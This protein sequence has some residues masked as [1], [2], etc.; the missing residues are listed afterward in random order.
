MLLNILNGTF[1]IC[2]V[3]LLTL[4]SCSPYNSSFT[5]AHLQYLKAETK[6]V[7]K[8]AWGSY[9]TY[10]FPA[11][12]VR[13]LTC[14]P[15]GPD[16]NN[17]NDMIRNDAMGNISLTVLDNLDTLIIMEEWDELENMLEYLRNTPDIF[18]QDT[19]V[20]VFELSIRSLG[21]L[22]SA[23]LLLTDVT[24]SYV[25]AKFDKFKQVCDGYDGFL[26]DLAYDL[27]KRLIPTYKTSN[28]IPVPRVNL[29]KGVKDVPPK[30][31]RDACTAGAT[32]PVLEFTLL[33]RLTGDPQFEHYTQLTFWKFWSSKLVLNLLPMT[34]D[35]IAYKW[36]D[37]LTGIGAS[38][39]SFYEYSAKAAII[40][41]DKYMWSVFK[42]SYKALLTHL[43]I[44]GGAGDAT[45]IFTN[46]GVYDGVVTS[47]WIDLLG[48][49]WAGLQV[50]T[51]QVSDAIRT[52]LV[53]LKI[54]DTYDLIPER[55]IYSHFQKKKSY[56]VTDAI[57]LEWYPLRPEFIE[58]T[59]YLYRATKDPMYLKI[60]ER[61]LDLLNTRY[62]AKCG[63]SGVQDIR[64][65]K[66][67]NRMETFVL[68]ETLKYLYLLFDTQDES[69]LHSSLMN[70]KN[71]IFS[72]E[73]HP[74]WYHKKLKKER[75]GEK[76]GNSITDPLH[77]TQE[78][79]VYPKVNFL[80]NIT[81]PLVAT[82]QNIGGDMKYFEKKDPFAAKLDIC[83]ADAFKSMTNSTN[84]FMSSNYYEW[85]QLFSPDFKYI[86]T[87][88][89]PTYLGRT[90]LDGSS[91]ELTK[92]FYDKFTL[93]SKHQLYLQCPQPQTSEV[94]EVFLGDIKELNTVE[95]SK[96][97]LKKDTTLPKS[98]I[99][100][101][102]DVWVPELT[103]LR[104]TFE[105][106]RVGNIDSQGN[107]VSYK[108]IQSTR[109]DDFSNKKVSPKN[110]R[111]NKDIDVVLR[112]IK[113]NG[114]HVGKGLVVWT[115]PFMIQRDDAREAVVD[116]AS[117]GRVVLEGIPVEN[118]MVWYSD[119]KASEY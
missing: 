65:G 97:K 50:L 36:K 37:S 28:N 54:W 57:N 67:Q 49:F 46:V 87:L 25:P 4:G 79:L 104:I 38:V 21:G 27:G 103:A 23:H 95:V 61:V 51:G 98:S 74:L 112:I 102:E 88:K 32:T 31:Q 71:W 58:S 101:D 107:R 117:D 53:Y 66:R 85:D 45:M 62:R 41:N 60:G 3:S 9:I 7:F 30:F 33:S 80:R 91:I 20:Q 13:P 75:G 44:G 26:L 29:A 69:F 18:N 100:L 70:N 17:I 68:G 39:D 82:Y 83:E 1:L 81:L 118:L 2:I 110:K 96:L 105:K 15:Y 76:G 22:L 77:D 55:W 42:T 93:F 43:A 6:L 5:A 34:I 35:P 47:E 78:P 12:E 94:Y 92:S 84:S 111:P 14:E 8:H 56:T 89:R 113:V 90:S 19:I 64:T 99:V 16:F 59:Y 115:L 40:F 119:N 24:N 109:P 106:L 48:A 63:L 116:V 73:A 11:D 114:V 72:T 10:G 108:Y 52:H 86:N